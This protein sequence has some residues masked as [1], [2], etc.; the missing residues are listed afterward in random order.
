MVLRA[1]VG[2]AQPPASFLEQRFAGPAAREQLCAALLEARQRADVEG[3]LDFAAAV[4]SVGDDQSQALVARISMGSA[5]AI[6]TIHFTGHRHL[7]DSTL[8]RTLTI[9]ERAMLDVRN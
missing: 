7:N 3:R 2:F 9:A 1:S 4:Q 5:Y 6:R 8:R